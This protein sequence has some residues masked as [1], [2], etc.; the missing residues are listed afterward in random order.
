MAVLVELDS[1]DVEKCAC[2]GISRQPG[3]RTD[4]LLAL[5]LLVAWLAA[6]GMT[7]CSLMWSRE[8]CLLW[9][10]LLPAL[11]QVG[12]VCEVLRQMSCR[13]HHRLPLG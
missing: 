10:E 3:L 12:R 8:A 1:S 9:G 11:S 7:E 13:Q 2:G 4:D 6:F 5:S